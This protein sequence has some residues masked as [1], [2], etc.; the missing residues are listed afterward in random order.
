MIRTRLSAVFGIYVAIILGLLAFSFFTFTQFKQHLTYIAD[1]QNQGIE[2]LDKA[3]RKVFETHQDAISMVHALRNRN[4][5]A[6]ELRRY[7]ESNKRQEVSDFFNEFRKLIVWDDPEFLT[8]LEQFRTD[9][10]NWYS[11]FD[12]FLE[13]T[14]GN[15]ADLDRAENMLLTGPIKQKYDALLASL[16]YLTLKTKGLSLVRTREIDVSL[17]L[18]TFILSFMAVIIIVL[19]VMQMVFFQ[20]TIFK[21]LGKITDRMRQIARGEG[22]LTLTMQIKHRDEFGVLSG[23]FNDFI[24]HLRTG[25]AEVKNVTGQYSALKDQLVRGN[26]DVSTSVTRISGKLDDITKTFGDLNKTAGKTDSNVKQL[27]D[28]IASLD[29]DVDRQAG[30]VDEAS[31]SIT[32]MI[33]SVDGIAGLAARQKSAA[34]E[35]VHRGEE[36][37]EK[38]QSTSDAIDSIK[39][40]V[41]TIQDTTELISS[42]AEQ[43]NLLAM[44]AAIEAAHAGETG[45]GFV[46]VA[47]EIRTLAESTSAQSNEIAAV[48]ARV[49][50]GINYADRV[51][52]ESAESFNLIFNQIRAVTTVFS[53]ISSSMTELKIGGKQ[54][55]DVMASLHAISQNNRNEANQMRRQTQ[56]IADQVSAVTRGSADAAAAIAEID[57]RIGEINKAVQSVNRISLDLNKATDTIVRYMSEF[58]TE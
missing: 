8:G 52:E 20:L 26:V 41:K 36:G 4:V 33:H 48:L 51:K 47:D 13:L 53:E 28:E 25:I 54:I 49:V 7:I 16:D 22:D 55:L 17:D 50:D 3:V 23:N 43:T 21:N 30:M 56:G 14:E 40:S 18:S 39:D 35:L 9:W 57:A 19:S 5:V 27:R 29:Q 45:K 37:S 10:K 38:L 1:T 42:I 11:A 12:R 15:S 58:K 46:V 6:N 24:A 44:N 34:D 2:Y 31:A 32:E